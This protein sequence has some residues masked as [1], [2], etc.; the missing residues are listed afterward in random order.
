MRIQSGDRK[1]ME[2]MGKRIREIRRERRLSIAKLAAMAD[3]DP[4]YLVRLEKGGNP[5]LLILNRLAQCL[6]VPAGMLLP[7]QENTPSPQDP[8]SQEVDLTQLRD[9]GVRKIVLGD[10]VLFL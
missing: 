4:S 1:T 8:M 10:C 5:S 7:E 3:M 2:E 6:D 9:T